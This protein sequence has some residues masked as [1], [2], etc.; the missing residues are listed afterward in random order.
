MKKEDEWQDLAKFVKE[1]FGVDPF[2]V[3]KPEPEEA[4]SGGGNA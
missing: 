3:N 4:K 1:K 2:P